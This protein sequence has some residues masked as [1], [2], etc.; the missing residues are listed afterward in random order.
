MACLGLRIRSWAVDLGLEGSERGCSS[1]FKTKEEEEMWGIELTVLYFA[2]PPRFA[3]FSSRF[4]SLRLF[5]RLPPNTL[6]RCTIYRRRN[7]LLPNSMATYYLHNESDSDSFML[8][9]RRRKKTKGVSYVIGT[10]PMV[11]KR[12][13]GSGY[14][15][16]G[17]SG[18]VAKLRWA[19]KATG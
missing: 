14:G 9:A 10:D 13:G 15:K 7:P 16:G 5:R 6:L 17:Q 2:P 18:Y 4:H 11:L 19:S 8:A 3:S 1:T 12:G